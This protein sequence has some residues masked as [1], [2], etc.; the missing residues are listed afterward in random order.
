MKKIRV[1][2]VIVLLIAAV[3]VSVWYFGIGWQKEKITKLE[4]KISLLK[5]ET[6]PIR[7]KILEK[8]S[9]NIKV[10]IKFYDLDG[11]SV[12]RFEEVLKGNELSFDF[13]VVPVSDK[14]IAFPYKIFTNKIAPKN[15]KELFKYYDNEGFPQVFYT[16]GM[17]V[18]L[19]KGLSDLFLKVKNKEIDSI[20]GIYGS[21]VQDVKELSSFKTRIIYKIVTHTKGGIEIIEE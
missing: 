14:F 4:E 11:N 6:V 19:K 20:D 5:E 9:N 1:I 7:F 21:M 3:V 18:G 8:D 17:D 16:Q 10:A 12:Q 15:G 2:I 13:Y